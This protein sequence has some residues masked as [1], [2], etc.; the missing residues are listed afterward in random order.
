MGHELRIDLYTFALGQRYPWLLTS[1]DK[2]VGLTRGKR[3]VYSILDVHNVEAPVMALTMRN[4]THPTHVTSTSD[5]GD[6]TSIEANEVNN[7]A[8]LKTDLDG[9]IDLDSRVRVTNPGLTKFR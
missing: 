2:D 7:F 5:H 8:I 1:D 3:V 4:H 6:D 9:I